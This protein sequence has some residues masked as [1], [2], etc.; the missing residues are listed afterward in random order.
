MKKAAI[1]LSFA[2]AMVTTTFANDANLNE[3]V[4]KAF[5][6][7][8]EGA[9]NVSWTGNDEKPTAT[10]DL[11][12]I[13]TVASFDENGNL[14][15]TMRYYTAE[16]LPAHII[17]SVKKHYSKTEIHGVTEVVKNDE[18]NYHLSLKDSKN[19]YMV[20]SSATGNLEL[21]KKFKRGDL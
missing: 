16:N 14:L 2:I 6:T 1:I 17:A 10:F 3:K 9:S 18:I 20:K 19:W 13:R 15:R 5:S 11:N 4:L 7:A 21:E 8:F 12:K